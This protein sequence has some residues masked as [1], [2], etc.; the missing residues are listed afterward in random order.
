MGNVNMIKFKGSKLNIV[1]LGRKQ[2]TEYW[3]H[4]IRMGD[5]IET[6]KKAIHI[7]AKKNFHYELCISLKSEEAWKK[8]MTSWQ[9]V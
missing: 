6:N 5:W 3:I 7:K 9:I 4:Q 1:Y 8:L 2:P